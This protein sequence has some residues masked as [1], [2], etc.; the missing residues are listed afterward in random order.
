MKYRNAEEDEKK[1]NK[2]DKTGLRKRINNFK[3]EEEKNEE[4]KEEEMKGERV[5]EKEE[6]K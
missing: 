3:K 5:E 2:Y 6:H 1:R 4:E